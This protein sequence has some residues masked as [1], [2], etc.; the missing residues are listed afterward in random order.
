[1]FINCTLMA[2]MLLAPPPAETEA[3]PR[4]GA[5]DFS[6]ELVVLRHCLIDHERNSGIGAAL[7]GIM[8]ECLVEP[9]DEV[10]EGQVVGRLEDGDARA[11][12]QL[13]EAEATSTIDVR[14]SESKN[15]LAQNRLRITATLRQRN[16]ASREEFTQQKLE[17]EVTELEI[18]N[19][20]H[21]HDLAEAQLRHARA[22]LRAREFVSPHAGVVTEVLK[23]P[24]EPVAPNLPV[25][26]IVDVDHLLITG[27]VDV[28]D[29]W[30]LHAGQ[31][32]RVIPEIAGADLPV[33]REVFTG[34]IYFVDPHVDAVSQ[35]CKVL[36][37]CANRNRL[38]RAGVEARMEIP[39]PGPDEP[40]VGR[41][42]RAA[43]D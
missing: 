41:S 35:T 1:M 16:A 9:G 2:A 43:M 18:E 29:V 13:R 11:E 17:A 28:V 37:R 34:R 22:M 36:A 21:R 26:R 3:G 38:L 33:E 23:R 31:V 19:A 15:A 42:T 24:S 40:E 6:K 10:A 7:F 39:T 12:V 30:R 14:L 27:Q 4:A 8:K 25:F 20:R 32:V 5:S